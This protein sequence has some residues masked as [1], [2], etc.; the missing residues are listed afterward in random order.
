MVLEYIIFFIGAEGLGGIIFKLCQAR[1]LSRHRK[2]FVMIEIVLRHLLL[3]LVVVLTR[4]LI[5]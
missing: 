1:R 3:A 2:Y 4:K 5:R